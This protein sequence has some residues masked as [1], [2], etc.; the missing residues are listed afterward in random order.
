MTVKEYREKHPKCKYCNHC[1]KQNLKYCYAKEKRVHFNE[2]KKC[3]MYLVTT[4]ITDVVEMIK[5]DR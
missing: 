2:A 5:N 3:P 4:T 1:N